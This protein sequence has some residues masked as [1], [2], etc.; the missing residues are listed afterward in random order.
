MECKYELRQVS[1]PKKPLIGPFMER[2][3]ISAGKS[4][5]SGFRQ[6]IAGS[7]WR[8]RRRRFWRRRCYR[9]RHRH[10]YCFCYCY[11][12]C[13][14]RPSPIP[15]PSR[16]RIHIHIHIDIDSEPSSARQADARI[17]HAEPTSASLAASGAISRRVIDRSIW[18]DRRSP[19][20]LEL[21]RR[22]FVR[23]VA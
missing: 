18:P 23:S 8:R 19:V 1:R 14:W 20:R 7:S 3:R 4:R 2:P 12:F 10:R 15:S 6:S 9:H 13:Y 16:I 17:D 11:C 22:S 21:D 5:V